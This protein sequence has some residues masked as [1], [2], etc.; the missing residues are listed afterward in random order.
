MQNTEF[1]VD[2]TPDGRADPPNDGQKPENARPRPVSGASRGG[3]PLPIDPWDH[4]SGQIRPAQNVNDLTSANKKPPEVPT[5]S[6]TGDNV[7]NVASAAPPVQPVATPEKSPQAEAGA[8]RDEPFQIPILST[9]PVWVPDS[10]PAPDEVPGAW[11]HP[12]SSLNPRPA[13]GLTR[14][15]TRDAPPPAAGQQPIHLPDASGQT[16]PQPDAWVTPPTA[17]SADAPAVATPAGRADPP[18]TP[19][20]DAPDPA[21]T[22]DPP[23]VP[24]D[25]AAIP[26]HPAAAP[27]HRLAQRP[28]EAPA[29]MP[30]RTP[31]PEPSPAPVAAPA[32]PAARGGTPAARRKPGTDISSPVHSM[33]GYAHHSADTAL[34]R[35]TIEVRAVNSRFLDLHFRLA[36][37]LRPLEPFLRTA[38]TSLVRRGKVECRMTLQK[39]RQDNALHIDTERLENLLALSRQIQDFVPDAKPPTVA[40]YLRWLNNPDS[41][42]DSLP[43]DDAGLWRIV[44]PLAADCLDAFQQTRR[45]EGERLTQALNA[46]AGQMR[47][48]ATVIRTHLPALRANA[49]RR[50]LERLQKALGDLPLGVPPEETLARVRQEVSLMSLRDDITEEIDRLH[51]HLDAVQDALATGS[52]VGKRLD[53]LAQELNREA[54]TIASKSSSTQ[55]TD[56]AMTLKLLIEQ[57]REQVQ[58]LE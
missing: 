56:A 29:P 38:I 3:S 43:A 27:V 9:V 10:D 22:A 58:N 46:V 4:A 6:S 37:E 25:V 17:P 18:T 13:Q 36:D 35:I 14:A 50:L 12:A 30:A 2:D 57:L 42:P 33:T 15:D 51:I 48:L 8:E 23:P 41:A 49:E 20:T 5:S 47:K 21:P 16:P 55:I 44:A 54:N 45:Q 1:P 7:E 19:Q 24:E 39:P 52:P 31:V 53:F 26:A 11:Q 40:D 34:G 32:V 28:A